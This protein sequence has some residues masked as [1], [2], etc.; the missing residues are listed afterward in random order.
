MRKKL[1]KKRPILPDP[2]FNDQLVTRFVN[3]LMLHGKKSTAFC[4]FYDSIEIVEKRN[5]NYRTYRSLIKNSF[6]E[7]P[8]STDEEFISNFAYPV[9]HKNR[10]HL[11]KK[12]KDNNIETRPLICG[13]LG[14]QPFWTKNYGEINLKNADLVND[15]GFYLPNNHDLTNQEIQYVSE[16]LGEL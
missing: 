15:H 3:N 11:V 4:L 14:K 6:W 12:L 10:K 9:I 8:K 1:S 2:K 16:T 7:P 5:S 13:S